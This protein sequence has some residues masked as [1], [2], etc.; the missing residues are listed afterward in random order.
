MKMTL[1]IEEQ[2]FAPCGMNCMVCYKHCFTKKPCPGCMGM[3]TG[4]PK[5]CRSC[6]IKDCVQKKSLTYCY[7]CTD[8]P[9]KLINNLEKSYNK[10]YG[11][12]LIANSLIVKD[13]GIPYL[14]ETHSK[15]YCCPKCG[16]VIS[17]HDKVC[18]DCRNPA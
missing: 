2:M 11:E 9:C 4:K 7:E 15:I 10:R 12:S 14:L 18:S 8:F 16:G 17:L 13:N 5:H 6:K 3:N 1:K